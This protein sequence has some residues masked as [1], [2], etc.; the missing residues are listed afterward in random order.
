VV[1]G[2]PREAALIGAVAE[3]AA[4]GDMAGRLLTHLR[5]LDR[6]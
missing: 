6:G 3:V 5:R 4:L 2:M 1:Y